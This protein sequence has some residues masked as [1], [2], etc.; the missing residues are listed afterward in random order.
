MKDI[1]LEKAIYICKYHDKDK[2]ISTSVR[3]DKENIQKVID[4]LKSKGLYNRYRSMTEEEYERIIKT[5]KK[6]IIEEK[7][8]E[9]KNKLLD[10]NNYLFDE[11]N[12]LMKDD[13]TDEEL[14]REL[15]ISKQVVSVSQTII[16]NANL[17]LQAKKHFDSTGESGN[18]VASLLRLDG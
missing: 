7:E 6:I 12:T 5:K 17:L 10:L 13:L 14:D 16:N 1:D 15:K 9:P 4:T 2:Y 11:L 8:E 3:L 18:E